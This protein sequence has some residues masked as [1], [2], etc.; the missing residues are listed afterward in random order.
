[1]GAETCRFSSTIRIASR[2]ERAVWVRVPIVRTVP[3][4]CLFNSRRLQSDR[5]RAQVN[6]PHKGAVIRKNS[7]VLVR[8]AACEMLWFDMGGR[9]R[10]TLNYHESSL[11]PLSATRGPLMAAPRSLRPFLVCATHGK[12]P[13]PPWR[14]VDPAGELQPVFFRFRPNPIF[15]ARA[16]RCA[17]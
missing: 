12:A 9:I 13:R 11:P 3:V 8:L 7:D 10:H 16:D 17:A 15:F 6:R 2:S 4:L 1:M 5:F 14:L